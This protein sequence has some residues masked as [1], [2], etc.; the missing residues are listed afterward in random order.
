MFI[1]ILITLLYLEKRRVDA[2]YNKTVS[3]ILRIR[4]KGDAKHIEQAI[5]RNQNSLHAVEAMYQLIK[6]EGK[7]SSPAEFLKYQNNDDSVHRVEYAT[8][9]MVLKDSESM[10]GEQEKQEIPSRFAKGKVVVSTNA[11]W[12]LC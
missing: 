10:L 3:E 1:G 12:L 9:A 8:M 2:E 6:T 4:T 11:L 7:V 5:E